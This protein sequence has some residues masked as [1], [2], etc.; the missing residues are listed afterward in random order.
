M[1]IIRAKHLGMCFGVRDAIAL[2]LNRSRQN[3]LT[4]YGDL[5]HNE[6]VLT[7]LRQRGIHLL[8]EPGE[9]PTP[10]VMI[11]AHGAS[12]RALQD[13]RSR[14]LRI[15]EA[16]CPLVHHAHHALQRLVQEQYHP[17]II[18][19]RDHV[20]VRGM[21]EDLAEFDVVLTESDVATLAGHPRMGVVAQTTQ[22]IGK[23]HQLVDLI[24]QRF[25]HSEVRFEDTVCQPTKQRQS[26]AIEIAKLADVVV[27]V[28]GAH[29]NN[30]QELVSTCGRF[31]RR[32]HHVQTTADL[33]PEW[34]QDAEV[35]GLTAGTSTPDSTIEQVEQW[36]R[37]LADVAES[38]GPTDFADGPERNHSQRTETPAVATW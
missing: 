17:V 29:S 14:G 22:P 6:T 25:P 26:S 24:R 7:T 31:C 30:T 28:G 5:V 37:A 11:T 4:I 10:E 16:T 21:T 13:L 18:G 19:K 1:R 8:R 34:F 33:R 35:V 12:Q 38:A 23:V 2:A 3:P 9:V 15:S 20:E 27:V 32:V 36:L